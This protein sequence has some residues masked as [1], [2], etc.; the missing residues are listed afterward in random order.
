MNSANAAWCSLCH[1]P[2]TCFGTPLSAL[3][4]FPQTLPGGFVL[5]RQGDECI[6]ID[7]VSIPHYRYVCVSPVVDA[8]PVMDIHSIMAS[9]TELDVGVDVIDGISI[10]SYFEEW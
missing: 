8:A 4:S 1:H 3:P 2:W 6:V 5:T 7:G 9:I 10:F